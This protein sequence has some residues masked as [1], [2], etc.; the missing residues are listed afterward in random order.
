MSE[1]VKVFE[2]NNIVIKSVKGINQ[3]LIRRLFKMFIAVML[4]LLFLFAY[5][6]Q[7]SSELEVEGNIFDEKIEN[8][9]L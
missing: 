7:S 9:E 8:D 6:F 4:L 2:F 5:V 3:V 1:S